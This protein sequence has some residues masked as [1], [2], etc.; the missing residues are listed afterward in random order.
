M[1][2]IALGIVT[3]GHFQFLETTVL[4]QF[5]IQATVARM[6]NLFEEDTIHGWRN[7]STFLL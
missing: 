6:V 3:F 2:H 5:G 4:H 1:Q 7:F